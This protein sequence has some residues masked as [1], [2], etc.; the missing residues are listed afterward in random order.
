MAL[1]VLLSMLLNLPMLIVA[2]AIFLAPV[3]LI[4]YAVVSVANAAATI[5]ERESSG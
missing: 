5:A 4:V 2:G 3:A 1:E